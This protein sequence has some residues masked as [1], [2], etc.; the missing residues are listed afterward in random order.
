MAFPTYGQILFNNNTGEPE[1]AV[2]RT[3]FES[4]PARQ[5]KIKS[6]VTVVRSLSILYTPT[7]LANFETWFRGSECEFGANWFDWTD[8]RDGATKQARV[9][10][11]KYD[12]IAEHAGQGAQLM[13]RV[14]LSL[15]ML[16]G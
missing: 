4:G 8:Y 12:Y 1:P 5:F 16:E 15:E 9:Y 10:E 6:R 7:E 13:Y 2:I 3:D 11:G 14:T